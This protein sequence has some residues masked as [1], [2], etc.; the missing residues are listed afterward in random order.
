[1]A[2]TLHVPIEIEEYLKT[3]YEYDREFVDGE[4]VE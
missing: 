4:V 3:S 2:T 1:M